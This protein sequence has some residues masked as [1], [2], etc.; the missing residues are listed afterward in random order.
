MK[1]GGGR[2]SGTGSN[3]QSEPWKLLSEELHL[4]KSRLLRWLSAN[5]M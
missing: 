4:V 5:L 2:E 1:G 3:Y